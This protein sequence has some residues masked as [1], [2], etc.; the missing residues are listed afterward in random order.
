MS[1]WKFL[2][3]P[4]LSIVS[5][6]NTLCEVAS[7]AYDGDALLCEEISPAKSSKPDEAEVESTDQEEDSLE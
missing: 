1:L 4:A 5:P 7:E 2:H 3:C 6:E